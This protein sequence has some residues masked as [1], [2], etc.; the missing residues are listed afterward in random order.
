ML[1]FKK[2]LSKMSVLRYLVKLF[3]N[4]DPIKQWISNSIAIGG[5]VTGVNMG[6]AIKYYDQNQRTNVGTG[7]I[8][9][10][11]VSKGIITSIL[12]PVVINYVCCRTLIRE[13]EYISVRG[14]GMVNRWGLIYQL[15]P[16]SHKFFNGMPL[17]TFM[18]VSKNNPAFHL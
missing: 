15:L 10:C 17:R 11:A 7:Y 5:A 6:M 14:L 12:W 13:P 18:R 2:I 3:E 9:A 4:P 1:L 8:I 16:A